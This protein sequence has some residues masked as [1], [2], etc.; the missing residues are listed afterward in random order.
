MIARKS[1]GRIAALLVCVYVA[2]M[3]AG[4]TLVWSEEFDGPTID[5]S[6]WTYN[7][8]GSGFGNGEL[9]YY[10]ARPENIHIDSGSLVI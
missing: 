1:H 8:G 3:A 9:Q 5:H 7:V 10:T 4:Q 6:T 2:P